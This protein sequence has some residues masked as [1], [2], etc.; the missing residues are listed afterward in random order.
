MDNIIENDVVIS[1]ILMNFY[2][3][4]KRKNKIIFFIKWIFFLDMDNEKRECVLILVSF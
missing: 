3:F 2:L 1:Y 4:F